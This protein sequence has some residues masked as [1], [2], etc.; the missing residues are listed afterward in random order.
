MVG[1]IGQMR[2]IS[3]R[4]WFL[5]GRNTKLTLVIIALFDGRRCSLLSRYLAIGHSSGLK[6]CSFVLMLKPWFV[7]MS[8]VNPI[9]S[10]V[11]SGLITVRSLVV[12][13][14]W[15]VDCGVHVMI[16]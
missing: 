16:F 6:L 1:W 4:R 14:V 9:V 12:L 7:S 15:N 10:F 8:L 11:V 2:L 13:R 3:K 5:S